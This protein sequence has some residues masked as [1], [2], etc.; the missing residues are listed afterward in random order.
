M[1]V[2]V[3]SVASLGCNKTEYARRA[4]GVKFSCPESSVEIEPRK[5]VSWSEIVLGRFPAQKPSPEVA[6]D[7][8]RLAKWKAD[9]A[10]ETRPLRESLDS[11]EVFEG[12]GCGHDAL[13]GC[14][15]P[16]KVNGSAPM[17]NCEVADE[18]SKTP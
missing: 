3:V 10:E 4:F 16:A 5:D 1:L 8:A 14:I 7:P 18:K 11:A 9:Q 15:R 2:S 13:I 12:K 6:A 17:V